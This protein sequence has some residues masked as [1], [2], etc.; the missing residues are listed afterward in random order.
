MWMAGGAMILKRIT[1]A[2]M[3]YYGIDNVWEKLAMPMVM[4]FVGG[5]M[6]T[7]L[8]FVHHRSNEDGYDGKWMRAVIVLTGYVPAAIMAAFGIGAV[9]IGLFMIYSGIVVPLLIVLAGLITLPP[10]LVRDL[11]T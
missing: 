1:Q 10:V 3:T 8:M 2:D 4:M 9:I 11:W 7:C 6:S 5:L